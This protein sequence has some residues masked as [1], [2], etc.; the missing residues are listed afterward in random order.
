MIFLQDKTVIITGAGFS[1]PAKLPIQNAILKVMLEKPGLSFMN[2]ESE[3][4]SIKFLNSFIEVGLY[5]LSEYTKN[6][7]KQKEKKYKLLKK[8]VSERETIEQISVDLKNQPNIKAE[9]IEKILSKYRVTNDE[10]YKQLVILKEEIREELEKEKLDINL[11]DIFTSFD[12]TFISKEHS[13]NYTY[14]E[15]DSLKHS[16]MRLFIY[17][18]GLKTRKHL[19]DNQDYQQAIK[20]IDRRKEDVSIITTNW[21]TIFEK[22]LGLGG[23]KYELCLNDVYYRFD[24]KRKNKRVNNKQAIKFVKVHGSINWCKCLSCGTIS[25]VEKKLYG[26]FLFDDSIEEKCEFC[27]N[28][29]HGNQMLFQPEIITPTMIKSITNQLYFNTWKSAS[30]VLS[31]AKRIIFIGYTLPIAD[32]DFKY[33][34]KR[35]IPTDA[36]IDVVLVESD[37]PNKLPNEYGQLSNMYPKKRYEDLFSQNHITFFYEGFGKYFSDI[38]RY[39]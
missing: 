37:N 7:I 27:Q 8:L 16:L 4:V 34:L 19:F 5:L 21:D 32:Y 33:L 30:S 23:V 10:H 12:K 6:N 15:M 18:L 29:A 25:I 24:D 35:N 36:K 17:Y 11:E 26:D 39:N 2:D 9:D 20:F 38:N 22:Y 14:A 1:A 3:P 28:K 13:Q 31:H